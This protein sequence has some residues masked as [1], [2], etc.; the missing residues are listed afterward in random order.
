MVVR[1][2]YGVFYETGR[3]KFLDQMFWNSPGYGGVSFDSISYASDPNQTF[4]KLSDVFPAPIS[5]QK[6]TWPFRWVTWAANFTTANLRKPLITRARSHLTYS[7]GAW[8]FSA[9]WESLRS[10][11]LVTWVR[12]GPN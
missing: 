9:K 12:R 7:A 6:G 5:I 2:G 1:G 3:F 4:F 10:R 8:I 11:P